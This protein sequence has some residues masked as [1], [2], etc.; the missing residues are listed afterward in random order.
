MFIIQ[1]ARS[2]PI[3]HGLPQAT[4]SVLP[5][6]KMHLQF[7]AGMEDTEPLLELYL[8]FYLD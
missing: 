3:V 2:P 4:S 8:E 7:S 6:Q 5:S 1:N